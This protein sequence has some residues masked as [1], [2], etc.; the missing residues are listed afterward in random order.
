MRLKKL[1]LDEQRRADQTRIIL[2]GKQS[3][4]QSK[5]AFDN[6]YAQGLADARS[7]MSFES[8]I[9]AD[10]IKHKYTNPTHWP[11]DISADDE[12]G[13]A[14]TRAKEQNNAR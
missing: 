4:F 7:G 8:L 3:T 11:P 6:G 1:T 5:K 14:Y 13:R 10:K 9:S 2:C 12:I